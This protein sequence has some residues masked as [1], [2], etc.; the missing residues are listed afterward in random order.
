MDDLHCAGYRL[1]P[2]REV[3]L[4]VLSETREHLTAREI[5]RRA[6]RRLPRLHKSA[7]YRALDV[8]THLSLVNPID[9]GQGEIQYELNTQPHHHHL[10]C[11][12]CGK[13]TD[14]DGQAFNA[15]DT[16][17]RAEYG[18]APFLFHFAIFGVCRECQRQAK[19]NTRV[20]LL[21]TRCA[22]APSNL[23]RWSRKST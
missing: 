7:V 15:L 6:R 3:V 22:P 1:T 19:K 9:V 10:V 5:L 12:Q 14:V 17:L 2:Q 23:T 8:L 20:S 13:I 16:L 11:Q 4:E 18:F 21:L